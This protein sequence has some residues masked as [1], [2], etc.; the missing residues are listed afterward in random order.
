MK[1]IRKSQRIV[2]IL[3]LAIE[4]TPV[5]GRA[6]ERQREEDVR[7]QANFQTDPLARPRKLRA[8]RGALELG[9][10]IDPRL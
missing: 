10:A 3:L 9:L 2:L 5:R 4:N 8:D 7:P 1:P 6:G